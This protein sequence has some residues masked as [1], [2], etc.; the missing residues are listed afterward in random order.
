[1]TLVCVDFLA[2]TFLYFL[3]RLLWVY[4]DCIPGETTPEDFYWRV[5]RM[6]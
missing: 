1:M 4:M 5:E 6:A 2:V 3:H